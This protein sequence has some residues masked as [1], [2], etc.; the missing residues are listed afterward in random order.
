ME[1]GN[2]A[3]ACSKVGIALK[4]RRHAAPGMGCA[5][6]NGMH[7]HRL[8]RVKPCLRASLNGQKRGSGDL[9]LPPL[10]ARLQLGACAAGSA[11]T[12]L[13]SS[14]CCRGGNHA[15]PRPPATERR[16]CSLLAAVLRPLL[17]VCGVLT[18][19]K[20]QCA[21]PRPPGA[22]RAAPTACRGAAARRAFACAVCDLVA[23]P[24]AQ[25]W[26]CT[27]LTSSPRAKAPPQRRSLRRGCPPRQGHRVAG[28]R[29]G[30]SATPAGG[31]QEADR[32]P[33]RVPC[34]AEAGSWRQE[35][36]RGS[37]RSGDTCRC[38]WAVCMSCQCAFTA[39]LHAG[40]CSDP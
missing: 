34:G 20:A 37:G 4:E 24:A 22:S 6:L 12:A 1:T 33:Y 40:L 5:C 32:L 3:K 23:E 16:H 13:C 8:L 27:S 36:G 31:M 39:W 14:F 29:R 7:G 11:A 9:L 2:R 17:P 15:R 18:S 19:T 21:S 25:P 26:T 10:T 35:G 38:A 28:C 30:A